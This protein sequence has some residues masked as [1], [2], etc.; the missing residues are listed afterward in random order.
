L[1]EEMGESYDG[2]QTPFQFIPSKAP[3]ETNGKRREGEI[4]TDLKGSPKP[5]VAG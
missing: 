4:E 1:E 2:K 5:F 3:G